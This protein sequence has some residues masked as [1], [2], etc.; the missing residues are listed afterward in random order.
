MIAICKCFMMALLLD[1]LWIYLSKQDFHTYDI[2]NAKKR[3]SREANTPMTTIRQM[4]FERKTAKNESA[5]II[6]TS[7][8]LKYD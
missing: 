8:K 1:F 4:L 6:K 3:Y 7:G 5:K 2:E